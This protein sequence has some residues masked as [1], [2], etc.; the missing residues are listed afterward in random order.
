LDE[1]VPESEKN[2]AA[3]DGQN[4][5]PINKVE[6]TET[7]PAV[8][9]SALDKLK[10]SLLQ[11]LAVPEEAKS[12]KPLK[13]MN[14][15][16]LYIDL[17]HNGDLT[18]DKVVEAEPM[19][20]RISLS[21]DNTYS[22]FQFPRVDV[23]LD[24]E[25]TPVDYAF[26][27]RG[28]VNISK[29]FSY[30]GVQINSAAYREGDITLDG[31][32]HHLVLIDFNSNGRFDDQFKISDQITR[33]GDQ[34]YPEQGDMLYVDPDQNRAGYSSP[35]DATSNPSQHYVSKMVVIDGKYYDLKV[36]IAG[37]KIT[38]DPSSVK[39]GNV[40]NPNEQFGAVIYGDNGF[41]KISGG[42][43]KP[44]PVP[45]GD[46]KLLSYTINISESKEPAKP[47]EKKEESKKTSSL[48]ALGKAVESVLGGGGLVVSRPGGLLRGNSIVTAQAT[49]KYKPVT[50]REGETVE[51]P[52]GP[53]YKP[54]V[55]VD[56]VQGGT[57]NK[58][59]RLGMSLTGSAGE[60]VSNMMVGGSRPEKP[61]FTIKDPK[62]EVVQ[63]GS[64]EYG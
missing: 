13:A 31:K 27:V 54:I 58:E 56:Y 25:G 4:A 22:Q 24:I 63:T 53:P 45:A 47:E 49:A 44:V 32:K 46:W 10:S 16:R 12:G 40:T 35:F 36:S 19:P 52:F 8:S 5:E 1:S 9:N 50:V 39:L 48:E 11:A 28:Y 42:K 43:D 15:N 30:A 21:S 34:L 6:K 18:D 41:L 37:D 7:K 38:L 61:E 60:V 3:S 2:K 17:N 55:S 57:T 29:D 14:F 64:F 20:G 62:G 59:A 26:F 51:M 23:T 33:S